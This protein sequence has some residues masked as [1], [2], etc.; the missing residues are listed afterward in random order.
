MF[1]VRKRTT[2]K[3]VP[4]VTTRV[5]TRVNTPPLTDYSVF[6]TSLRTLVA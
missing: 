6:M 3:G 1:N 4:V 5:T 2:P